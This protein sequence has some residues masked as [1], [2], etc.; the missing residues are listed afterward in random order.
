MNRRKSTALWVRAVGFLPALLLGA[1]GAD[2]PV[3]AADAGVDSGIAPPA[4]PAPPVLTPCPAGWREVTDAHGLVTCDPWPESGYRTDCAFD[5]A[6]FAGPPGCA[7]I[8]T[9]CAADGWPSDL[10]TDRVIVY[11]DDGA[12]PGGDGASRGTAFQR[13]RDAVSASPDGVVIAVATGLYDE[14]VGLPT[15]V[16]LW[17]ACV[18]GTRL[19]TSAPAE[20][21]AALTFYGDG[22]GARN[23][24]V[25]GV[26]RPG[27]IAAG[28]AAVAIEAVVVASARAFGVGVNGGNF[29]ASNVVVRSTRDVADGTYAEGILVKRGA[30]ATLSRVLVE[31]CRGGGLLSLEAGTVVEASDLVVRATR[32]RSRDATIGIG[33][34]IQAGA[35]AAL[36]RTV[37]DDNRHVGITVEGPGSLLQAVD[38]V[39]RGTRESAGTRQGGRAILVAVGAQA[40][41]SKVTVEDNREEGL[42]LQDADTYAEATDLVVR[43]TRARGSDASLGEGIIAM[44]GAHLRVTRAVLVD[45]EEDGMFVTDSGTT[46]DGTDLS[47]RDTQQTL[48]NGTNGAGVWFQN[49]ARATLERVNVER[50]H[51]VGIASVLRAALRITELTVSSVGSSLCAPDFC[52]GDTGGFGL[53]AIAGGILQVANFL[54]ADVTL[55][56]V[57]VGHD[58]VAATSLDVESGAIDRSMIGACVQQEGYDTT[59]L[60][61]GVEYRDVGVPLRATSYEIPSALPVGVAP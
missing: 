3:T 24:G 48:A 31:D 4:P 16:T 37:V 51:W 34:V 35:Q 59:R 15:G 42:L 28:G 19:V 10:P 5:E 30:H 12:A 44:R 8:G 47:V 55:C 33:I 46:V 22:S 23:L 18:S 27:L 52:M 25:D 2:I 56:G 53:V 54:I 9:E 45:N 38:V 36:R 7:R 39:V 57:V 49:G 60:Q 32:E 20:T 14:V 41:L 58:G 17:G 61:H 43:G 6:H 1:C 13:I 11:V 21:E 50:S 29:V 40:F 26:A